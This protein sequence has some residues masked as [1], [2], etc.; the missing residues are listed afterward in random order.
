MHEEIE[1][2]WARDPLVP[3]PGFGFYPDLVWQQLEAETQVSLQNNSNEAH[4]R[5][6]VSFFVGKKKCKTMRKN[7][8]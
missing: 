3:R 2:S 4:A 5:S 8:S 1:G 6:V 7:S